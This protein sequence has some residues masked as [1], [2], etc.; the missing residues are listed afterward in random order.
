MQMRDNRLDTVERL[1]V[2]PDDVVQGI[3]FNNQPKEYRNRRS[4]VIRFSPPFDGDVSGSL[5]HSEEGTYYPPEMDPKPIHLS[6]D[7]FLGD[8]EIDIPERREERGRAK[9][10]L[11]NPT[12]DQIDGWVATAFEVWEEHARQSLKEDVSIDGTTVNVV[13]D[14]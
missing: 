12:E 11:D 3:K 7:E 2:D 13:Y 9:E 1:C 10:E 14:D 8:V 4:A 5:Y 6:P